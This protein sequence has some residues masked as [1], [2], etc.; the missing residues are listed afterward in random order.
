[1]STTPYLD[2]KTLE[3]IE[4]R[5]AEILIHLE[6]E[7]IERMVDSGQL[8]YGD[9]DLPRQQRLL[10]YRDDEGQGVNQWLRQH[11]PEEFQRRTRAFVV[12]AEQEGVL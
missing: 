1:M 2:R 4:E 5:V 3:R 10:K 8:A 7:M 11:E 12:D 6:D 9:L